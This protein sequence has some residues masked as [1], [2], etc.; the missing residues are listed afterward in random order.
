[1][2]KYVKHLVAQSNCIGITSL[3]KTV[4]LYRERCFWPN[5]LQKSLKS[6]ATLTHLKILEYMFH[7][8]WP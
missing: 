6:C 7:K 4:V 1:M 5:I 3:K 8:R 2:L